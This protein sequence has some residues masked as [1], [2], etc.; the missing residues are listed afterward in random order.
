MIETKK[1]LSISL[2]FM[3]RLQYETKVTDTH[4]FTMYKTIMVDIGNFEELFKNI[5]KDFLELML[6]YD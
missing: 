2:E 4:L 6:K 5:K 1:K 3:E